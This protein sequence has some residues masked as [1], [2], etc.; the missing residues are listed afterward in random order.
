MASSLKTTLKG[1]EN[2]YTMVRLYTLHCIPP[3]PCK[4]KKGNSIENFENSLS[5]S[6]Q[7]QSEVM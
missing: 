3:Q 2:I 4:F 5:R 7:S 6:K 1:V